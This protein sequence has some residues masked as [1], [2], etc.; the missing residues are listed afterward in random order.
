MPSDRAVTADMSHARLKH[1]LCMVV[2]L[3]VLVLATPLLFSL[4]Q[5]DL[6]ASLAREK[7]EAKEYKEASRL[8]ERSIGYTNANPDYYYHHAEALTALAGESLYTYGNARDLLNRAMESYEKAAALNPLEGGAWLGIAYATW[9]LG[10]FK[11]RDAQ[12]RPSVES[13]FLKALET[14]PNSSRF[15]HGITDYYLSFREY[16]K[17]GP[18]LEKLATVYPKALPHLE[19][20]RAWSKEAAQRFR[21]GLRP[22]TRNPLVDV[23][24]LLALVD[25]AE[26]QGDWTE[27]EACMR[28]AISRTRG[29][30]RESWFVRLGG[31]QLQR[32]N[33]SDAVETFI[34]V[35]RMAADRERA[36]EGILGVCRSVGAEGFV[37]DLRR[38]M[39]RLNLMPESRSLIAAGRSFLRS[40]DLDRAVGYIE[41]ALRREES[42]TA[43]NLLAEAALSRKEWDLAERQ[44]RRAILLEPNN[45]EHYHLL[46]R[47]LDVQGKRIPAIDAIADAV[48]LARPSAPAHYHTLQGALYWA[49]GDFRK[50]LESW[51]AGNR[52]APEDGSIVFLIARAY[53][54]LGDF[55]AAER[56]CFA[57]LALKPGD[58]AIIEELKAIRTQ[59]ADTQ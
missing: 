18:Y 41:E 38:E 6:L 28:E 54:A 56:N 14:D 46:A 35:L 23:D 57:A 43:R 50:A 2:S 34:Q 29:K 52:I 39:S 49:V 24:A 45:S 20:H 42:A 7:L 40:G 32:G 44:V 1:R 53:G 9:R 17:A 47:C 15:L 30:A 3:A 10:Y 51:Q 21:S 37:D 31:F 26:E 33:R 27:A 13:F 19:K 58:K 22:A 11:G 59:M 5:A 25:L 48:R 4:I 12:W 55:P 16:S 36:F 8:L